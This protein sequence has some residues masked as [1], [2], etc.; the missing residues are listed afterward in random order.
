MKHQ[1]ANPSSFLVFPTNKSPDLINPGMHPL[2]VMKGSCATPSFL[3]RETIASWEPGL[4][5]AS[6]L[7]F[8]PASISFRFLEVTCACLSAK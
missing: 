3:P 8:A 4:Y 5:V 1:G 6:L 2:I 7:S